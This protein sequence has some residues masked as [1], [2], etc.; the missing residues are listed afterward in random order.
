MSCLKRRSEI[1]IGETLS[2]ETKKFFK[3][4]KKKVVKNLLQKKMNKGRLLLVTKDRYYS[5]PAS[6]ITIDKLYNNFAL[7][8]LTN[9]LSGDKIPYTIN[10]YS[11]IAKDD[12]YRLFRDESSFEDGTSIY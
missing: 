4:D 11:L 5:N 9:R 10:Y 7:G 6:V 1:N 2:S 3:V 8:H 12:N